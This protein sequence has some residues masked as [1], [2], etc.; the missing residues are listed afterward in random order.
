MNQRSI[1]VLFFSAVWLFACHYWYCCRVKAACYGCGAAASQLLATPTVKEEVP[2]RPLLFN[3]SGYVPLVNSAFEKELASWMTGKGDDNILEITGEYFE[4]E[5]APKEFA[6]LGLARADA[7]RTLLQADLPNERIRLNSKKVPL[8]S[9]VKEHSFSCISLQWAPLASRRPTVL[10]YGDNA[11]LF[12]SLNANNKSITKEMDHYLHTLAE[13]VKR[14]GEI[15]ILT[16]HANKSKTYKESLQLGLRRAMK[17]RHLLRQKGVVRD[18]IV[19]YPK[20]EQIPVASGN[21]DDGRFLN[22]RVVV[23]IGGK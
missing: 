1:L 19:A 23:E 4:E 3:W 21:T 17:I 22:R 16:G 14:S 18:Q 8:R 20:G 13:R 6:N 15:I 12:F 7:V 10:N 9:G 5:S 11:I 2:G